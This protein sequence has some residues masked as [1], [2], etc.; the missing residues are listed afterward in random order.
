[1]PLGVIERPHSVVVV[2]AVVASH[3]YGQ[4]RARSAALRKHQSAAVASLWQPR[5]EG[6]IASRVEAA[7]RWDSGAVGGRMAWPLLRSRGTCDHACR[8]SPMM[9]SP[10]GLES[11]SGAMSA[12]SRPSAVCAS[13]NHRMCEHETHLRAQFLHRLTHVDED[14]GYGSLGNF[15][16]L[17][18][19][20]GGVGDGQA[21]TPH[22]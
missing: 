10:S 18:S 11:R 15:P 13:T 4:R 17:T 5:G 16:Q 12:R 20:H 1:M 22:H 7:S 9:C 6:A 2:R 21:R 3:L 19:K 14:F 8:A